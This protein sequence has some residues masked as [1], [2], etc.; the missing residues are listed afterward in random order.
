MD[1][2]ADNYIDD[3]ISL[4]ADH[5]AGHPCYPDICPYCEGEEEP[6]EEDNG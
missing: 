4:W 5:L 3:G 2:I 1:E 6:V